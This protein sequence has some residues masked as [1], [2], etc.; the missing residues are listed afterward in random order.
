MTL[1]KINFWL[2]V[3][4]L[5]SSFFYAQTTAENGFAN[6]KGK[7]IDTDNFPLPGASVLVK[8]NGD[9]YATTTDFD[10]KFLIKRIPTANSLVLEI[11]YIG[12]KSITQNIE[13]NAGETKSIPLIV[14]SEK[15]EELEGVTVTGQSK[16]RLKALNVE[17]NADNILNVVSLEQA[18]KIPDDNIGDVLKRVSGVN[19]ELDQGEARK[20]SVRGLGPSSTNVLIDGERLA[21]TSYGG[22]RSVELDLIPANVIQNIE[23]SKSV[24]ADMDGESNGATVNLVTRTALSQKTQLSGSAYSSFT[25]TN[26]TPGYNL[27]M[28]IARRFYDNKLGL[29]FNAATNRRNYKS[30][31]IEADW[32]FQPSGDPQSP[33]DDTR[34][35]DQFE[36]RQYWL[37]RMRNSFN[38]SADYEFDNHNFIGFKLASSFRNDYENRYR[39]RLASLD[40]PAYF[41]ED[42]IYVTE[43]DLRLETTGG[44]NSGK[45]NGYRLDVKNTLYTKFYGGHLIGN[46]EIDWSASYSDSKKDR[47]RREIEYEVT[48]GDFE[49]RIDVTNPAKPSFEIPN[50]SNL[51]NAGLFDLK[52]TNQF[53][54]GN[55]LSL[56]M[57]VEH[58]TR[59]GYIKVGG[60]Y[61]ANKRFEENTVFDYLPT[62]TDLSQIGKVPTIHYTR[63][64]F[65]PGNYSL[66]PS[67]SRTFLGNL[68][69]EGN[70]FIK[71]Q[72]I[73][74]TFDTN[75]TADERV[76]ASYG[77]TKIEFNDEFYMRL[78]LRLEQTSSDYSSSN[79]N[80]T[81]GQSKISE[82]KERYLSL[83]PSASLRYEINENL[84]LRAGFS[85]TIRRPTHSQIAPRF[86]FSGLDGNGANRIFRGN[87]DLRPS[88]SYNYDIS[89]KYDLGQASSISIDSYMKR[90]NNFI[91]NITETEGIGENELLTIDSP[92]NVGKG[93]ITGVEVTFN[94]NMVDVWHRLRNFSV[95]SNFAFNDG[96]LKGYPSI[97][98]FREEEN[99]KLNDTS[100]SIYNFSLV[101]SSDRWE[102]SGS[103]HGS[104]P[105]LRTYRTIPQDDRYYDK[106]RFVDV[107]ISYKIKK[108]FY[109]FLQG[110]N[111]TN[112]PLRYFTGT[113]Q[114]VEQEEFYGPNF[115]CGLRY[116]L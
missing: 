10:G 82:N 7:I 103:I 25:T 20:I 67:V 18:E 48:E 35:L 61:R 47:N 105:Y 81:T 40:F 90:I 15:S 9:T 101:F 33:F 37:I 89:F 57:D 87:P 102:M 28:N 23:V 113:E 91:A 74:S 59:F 95:Y 93:R 108:G 3:S 79:Y 19:V 36:I 78:G 99:R 53:I 111:L 45:P 17:R 107:N 39:T 42:N 52:S 110:K 12:Y 54:D 14:M 69:L 41:L 51:Y 72:D 116:K 76:F 86:R 98:S 115:I 4:L 30:D 84:T 2:I 106:Q 60:R 50:I 43:G 38:I 21:S 55:R 22:D 77:L 64:E 63:S 100:D 44:V 114:Y 94:L 70:G 62:N 58:P 65:Y 73:N 92:V 13:L 8:T 85:R 104:S 31:N 1:H 56:S 75:Y 5:F 11:T 88:E 96:V 71:T 6:L 112:Q 66:F 46:T 27:E 26:D 32:D 109:L 24:S 29:S 49:V 80:E 16:G 34:F 68:D 97:N 83:L